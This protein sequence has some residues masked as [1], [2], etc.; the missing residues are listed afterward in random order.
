M[1]NLLFCCLLYSSPA[2]ATPKPAPDLHRATVLFSVAALADTLSTYRFLEAG[3][4]EEKN[5]I[6]RYMGQGRTNK[7]T[8]YLAVGYAAEY[9]ALK[10]LSKSRPGLAKKLIYAQAAIGFALAVSNTIQHER[11][12]RRR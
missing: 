3:T 8:A 2:L 7:T 9:Y 1:V 4:L 11:A 5:P 12:L 6:A 10:R